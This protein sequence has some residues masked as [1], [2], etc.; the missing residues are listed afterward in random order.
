MLKIRRGEKVSVEQNVLAIV[1]LARLEL[2]GQ[3]AAHEIALIGVGQ[4]VQVLVEGESQP[5][6]GKVTRIATAVDPGTRSI[7]AGRARRRPRAST[8]AMHWG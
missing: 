5:R 1:D 3:V 6:T 7:P 2:A 8:A 4:V